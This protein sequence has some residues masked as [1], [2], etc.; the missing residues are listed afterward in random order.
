M[1]SLHHAWKSKVAAASNDP[2]QGCVG[3]SADAFK[4]AGEVV[5]AGM[6]A[7]KPA[8]ETDTRCPQMDTCDYQGKCMYFVD[9]RAK[10]PNCLM[11]F[12]PAELSR[13][14]LC[15]VCLDAGRSDARAQYLSSMRPL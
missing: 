7:R 10:C 3:P 8:C 4:R 2:A 12:D 13:D 14:G 15:E 1:R 9:V 6:R 11:A 5:E